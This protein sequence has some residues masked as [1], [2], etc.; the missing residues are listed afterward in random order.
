M[1]EETRFSISPKVFP[2]LF[3]VDFDGFKF[4]H[5]LNFK[6]FKS[7]ANSERKKI[8]HFFDE[9]K[10]KWNAIDKKRKKVAR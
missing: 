4:R 2:N 3:P 1:N 8:I 7:F 6:L 10:E 5:E 9:K